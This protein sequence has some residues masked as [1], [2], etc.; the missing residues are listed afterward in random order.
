[1]KITKIEILM[2]KTKTKTA[3]NW[4]PVFCRIYTDEGVYGDGEAAL[5]YASGAAAAF[6]LL[7]D[8]GGFILGMNPL[9]NEVIWD[10]LHKTSFW[11]QNGGPVEFAAIS[12]IDIALWDIKGKLLN[13]PLYQLLGGKFRD[14]LRCYA[15]QLHLNGWRKNTD[16]WVNIQEP[17]EYYD[18]SKRAAAEGYT[19]IKTDF[20]Y[21]HADGEPLNTQ[22]RTGL[23][24]AGRLAFI[25]QRVAATR[26]A[27]GDRVDII[28]ENHGL[29]DA[30]GAVQ[31]G[32]MAEKYNIFFFEEAVTPSPKIA[33]IVRDRLNLPQAM[34]ERIYSRWQF[35][36]YFEN[37]AIQ[38]AQPDIGNCGGITETKKICDMAHIY[39]VGIQIHVCSSPLLIDAALH[40]EAAIPNFQIHEHHIVNENNRNHEMAL[41]TNL[42]VDGYIR[43]SEL[44]GIGNEIHPRVFRENRGHAVIE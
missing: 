2:G 8:Y 21:G 35:L 17:Q 7:R 4:R 19:C 36:P 14:S 9:D 3:D 22:T 23:F 1:M 25:E 41:C 20:L 38:I 27:V 16:E 30:N 18:A 28:M 39:D 34:G 43:P 29:L 10:K 31:L 26:E 12:A 15:S 42:P 11:A 37:D 33:K 32:R 44:P 24:P 5:A 13:R 6:E 40:L